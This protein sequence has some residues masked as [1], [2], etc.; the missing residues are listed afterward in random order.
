[1][2][3]VSI[4]T[5]DRELDPELWAVIWQAKAPADLKLHGAYNLAGNKRLYLWETDSVAGLQFMDNFNFIGEL[6][7][8]PAFDRTAGWTAA[9]AGDLEA[10]RL[11]H[12][13]SL[14]K[15]GFPPETIEQRLEAATD[16]RRRGL[17]A[18][19]IEAARRA[20]RNWAAGQADGR[21]A[22]R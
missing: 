17:Q 22:S 20:A 21:P 6:V 13:E 4:L 8:Y 12:R 11:A 7:T 1:M 15:G 3:Y 2:L 18:P 16:L 9:F 5:S 19:T 14:A 10:F